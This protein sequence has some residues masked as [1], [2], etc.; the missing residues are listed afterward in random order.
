MRQKPRRRGVNSATFYRGDLY[1][2]DLYRGGSF[3]PPPELPGRLI[4]RTASTG[5]STTCRTVPA[6][7]PNTSL[8]FFRGRGY[9]APAGPRHDRDP[10][11]PQSGRR[12][13][14]VEV[15]ASSAAS[16]PIMI[17]V[18]IQPS[19]CTHRGLVNSPIRARSLVK[20]NCGNAICQTGSS[21]SRDWSLREQGGVRATMLRS[22]R[23]SAAAAV[24]YRVCSASVTQS[25]HSIADLDL[26]RLPPRSLPCIPRTCIIF[27]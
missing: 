2:G 4:S 1:W 13:P 19:T 9:P 11:P 20:C 5:M 10:N 14:L 18:V 26:R 3:T 21:D 8:Q 16:R 25:C 12:D 27:R 24:G 15:L 6:I 17:A 7:S 22:L 23:L